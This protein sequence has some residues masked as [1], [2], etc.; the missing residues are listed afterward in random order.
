MRTCDMS[1]GGGTPGLLMPEL[2]SSTHA[3]QC[4]VQRLRGSM[5][6]PSVSSGGP[7]DGA[8]ATCAGVDEV[9]LDEGVEVRR[10]EHTSRKRARQ[11][12]MSQRTQNA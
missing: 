4:A 12:M 9:E 7:I 3:R 6:R 2:Y 1:G 5:P 8:R 11:N 10:T